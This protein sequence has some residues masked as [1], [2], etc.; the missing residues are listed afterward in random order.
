[1][2]FEKRMRVGVLQKH[3]Y[4]IHPIKEGRNVK[5]GKGNSQGVWLKRRESSTKALV[6]NTLTISHR[7]SLPRRRRRKKIK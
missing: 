7:K 5:R 1:M 2:T 6:I 3:E 4:F